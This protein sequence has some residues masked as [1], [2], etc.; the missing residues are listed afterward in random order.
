MSEQGRQGNSVTSRA[1]I[2]L[3]EVMR[4]TCVSIDI[5]LNDVNQPLCSCFRD[6]RVRVGK[7]A[8]GLPVLERR[9]TAGNRDPLIDIVL[10][11]GCTSLNASPMSHH[12]NLDN[13]LVALQCTGQRVP[14]NHQCFEGR[15]LAARSV[16]EADEQLRGCRTARCVKLRASETLAQVG[17]CTV[18]A[19]QLGEHRKSASDRLQKRIDGHSRNEF[20]LPT[21]SGGITEQTAYPSSIIS[22]RCAT[23]NR[24]NCSRTEM[25]W[26]RSAD[27]H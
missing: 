1:A 19:E 12:A 22:K 4:T 2:E 6:V 15:D 9:L 27:L 20:Q 18:V 10:A 5:R 7:L 24:Y 16:D 14:Q 17:G 21:G 13:A 8:E 26:R 11:F 25:L 23:S 3:E